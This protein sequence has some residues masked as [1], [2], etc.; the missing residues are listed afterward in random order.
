LVEVFFWNRLG[1]GGVEFGGLV[2]VVG[3]GFLGGLVCLPTVGPHGSHGEL[4]LRWAPGGVEDRGRG[5]LAD[6]GQDLA[7][8]LGV[9]A[10]AMKVRGFWQVGQ[11]RGKTS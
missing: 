2:E 9:G 7:D 3:E 8:G 10:N 6:V 5:G 11:M 4:G 1:V